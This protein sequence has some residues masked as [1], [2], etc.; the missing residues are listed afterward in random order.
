[1]IDK[2]I[3]KSKYNPEGSTLRKAQIRMT[4]LLEFF[5]NF[6]KKHHLIYWLDSGT[7]LGAA[8][9]GGFIPWDDDTDVMM[10]LGDFEKMKRLMLKHNGIYGDV[11]FQCNETDSGFFASW[12]TLRD[13]NSEYIQASNF[14]N[15]RKYRGLQVDI[16]PCIDKFIPPLITFCQHYQNR[17]IDRPIINNGNISKTPLS[18]LI[19]FNIFHKVVIPFC[20]FV[21]KPFKHEYVRFG[22]GISFKSKRYKKNIFPLKKIL[23]E[24]KE[25]SAPANVSEYLSDIYG[26][27]QRMPSEDEI[28]THDV[29]VIFK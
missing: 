23:F 25:F 13:V 29:E 17:L 6:C 4:S 18:T 8:R 28:V 20:N 15:R 26:D 22:Y 19:F 1:M 11:V 7:L 16:F 3:L 9:H 14:H 10:P 27:W 21:G 5:D 2:D 12:M 24:N